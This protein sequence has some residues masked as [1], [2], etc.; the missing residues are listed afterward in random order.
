[1]TSTFF[2]QAIIGDKSN[3]GGTNRSPNFSLAV[4]SQNWPT[5]VTRQ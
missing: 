5:P 2:H 4:P 3:N 1:L